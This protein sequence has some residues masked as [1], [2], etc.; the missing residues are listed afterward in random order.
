MSVLFVQV[1]W[2]YESDNKKQLKAKLFSTI[3]VHSFLSMHLKPNNV[4]ERC[5]RT[6]YMQFSA[7]N[8]YR[9]SLPN[10]IQLRTLAVD[11]NTKLDLYVVNG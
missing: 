4:K 1:Y 7:A 6:V 3:Y 11:D 8:I 2:T 5:R 10:D 9:R